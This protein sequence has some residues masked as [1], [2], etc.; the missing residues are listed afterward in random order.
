MSHWFFTL[1]KIY[2]YALSD[3]CVLSFVAT[4]EEPPHLVFDIA[5][6]VK[7]DLWSLIKCVLMS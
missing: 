2:G 6:H 4:S 3:Y 7:I 1:L 5:H